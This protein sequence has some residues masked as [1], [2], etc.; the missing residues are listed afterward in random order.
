M[1]ISVRPAS[2][3]LSSVLAV[4]PGI[5]QPP[6]QGQAGPRPAQQGPPQTMDLVTAKKIVQGAEA[7]AT[8]VNE[9]VAI[10]VMDT[11][12]DVVLSE[13]MDGVGHIPTT[14]AQGKARSV[15]LF[16]MPTGQIADAIAAKKPVSTTPK[17][18]PV[19]GG[20]G[21]ITLMRGGLP[22]LMDG[23]LVGAVG[24]GGSASEND[25]KFAQKGIDSLG[26]K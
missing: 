5:A 9:H 2:L 14:T 6:Q 24:V 22:V 23:K 18:P 10:C 3:L 16:G 8:A 19:G 17:A 20:G 7:A 26:S 15:L 1:K 4:T 13:R 12:G 11:N 21:E 25:E